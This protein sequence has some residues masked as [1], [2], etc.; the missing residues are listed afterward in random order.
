MKLHGVTLK[1]V[2]YYSF[3]F[4]VFSVL[5]IP[6]TGNKG[7]WSALLDFA[8]RKEAHTP[9]EKESVLIYCQID[10]LLKKPYNNKYFTEQG[11][12]YLSF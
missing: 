5:L 10:K 9:T 2:S 6:A 11:S 3:I 4:V 8:S 1:I 12:F 7:R